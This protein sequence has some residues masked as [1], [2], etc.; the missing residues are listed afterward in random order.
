MEQYPSSL[1]DEDDDL[2]LVSLCYAADAP[3][4]QG[5]VTA[6]TWEGNPVNISCEVDAHPT[7]SVVWFREGSELLGA[8]STNIKIYNT[9]TISYLEVC[10]TGHLYTH[11]EN[12]SFVLAYQNVQA[13][14]GCLSVVTAV[15]PSTSKKKST[16]RSNL[17]LFVA[18]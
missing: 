16:I 5:A 7:A 1:Q 10:C 6:Y 13:T 14:L 17:A 4:V 18:L 11:A 15:V 9:P 8:N 2:D 12:D 3:K